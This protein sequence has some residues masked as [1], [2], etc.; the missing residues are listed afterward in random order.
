MLRG[1][2]GEALDS[3]K[4]IIS[5]KEIL[6]GFLRRCSFITINPDGSYA[7]SVS[8]G[9]AV[10]SQALREIEN[11]MPDI[12]SILRGTG[13]D[14]NLQANVQNLKRML[15][16]MYGQLGGTKNLD[17]AQAGNANEQAKRTSGG[18]DLDSANLRLQETGGR[19]DFSGKFD[20]AVL[21]RQID[22]FTPIVFSITPMIN[23]QAFFS[24]N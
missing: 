8:G 21:N 1:L 9:P 20:P 6:T 7:A 4:V 16:S 5:R 14:S 11:V 12:N 19:I 17:L 18:I 24:K 2:L 23:L 3:A 22:G 15:G 13:Q 10:V